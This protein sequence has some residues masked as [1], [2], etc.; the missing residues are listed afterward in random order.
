ME[1]TD[2]TVNRAKH[3]QCHAYM[4]FLLLRQREEMNLFFIPSRKQAK[5]LCQRGFGRLAGGQQMGQEEGSKLRRQVVD[6]V[7]VC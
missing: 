3:F 5:A 7:V 4:G 1:H 6:R 2:C